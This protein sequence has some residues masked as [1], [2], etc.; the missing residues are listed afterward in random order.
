MKRK[1]DASP[2]MIYEVIAVVLFFG[3]CLLALVVL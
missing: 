3:M 1:E 2:P